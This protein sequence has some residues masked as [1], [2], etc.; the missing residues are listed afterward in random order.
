MERIGFLASHRGTN[1]QAVI[2]ACQSGRLPAIPAV[3][4]S[5]NANSGALTRA[6]ALGI[7]AYHLSARGFA[8]QYAL[9]Q[10]MVKTLQRHLVD[11][12]LTVGYMKKLGPALL[13]TYRNRIINIHPSLLPQY[14]GQG[15]Y[16]K[17]VHEAVLAGGDT[18]TGVTVHLVNEDYD[19]G[20]ILAQARVPV[21]PGDDVE[22]LAGRVLQTE[23]AFLVETL[24][25]LLRGELQLPS[26]S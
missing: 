14:G 6:Q 5:N 26:V 10:A 18:E 22:S 12:V 9:D 23:H 17:H 1:M 4:I 15:M 21:M 25:R 24:G 8:D 13:N 2:D 3:V 7:P 11:W 20:P 19:Q 16:G